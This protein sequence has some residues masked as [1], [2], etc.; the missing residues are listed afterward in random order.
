MRRARPARSSAKRSCTGS[1]RRR[2]KLIDLIGVGRHR[3]GADDQVELRLCHAA[4][5]ARAPA[6]CQRPRRR[7]HPRCRRLSGVDGAADRRRGG[8]QAVRR[9]GQGVRGRRISG[10][11]GVDEWAS[12][13]LQF[14]G[15][16]VAEVSCSVSVQQENVLRILGT[17]G[18]HRGA[19]LLV[20]RRQPRRRAGARSHVIRDDGTRETLTLGETAPPLFVRGGRR[21]P[22][23]SR[24]GRQEFAAPGMSWADSLGNLAGARQVAGR[25]R[26]RLRDREAGAA[27]ARR[28]RAGSS[29]GAATPIADDGRCRGCRQPTSLVALGFEFFPTFAQRVDHC[30]T[31]S[32]SAAATS[33]IPPGSTAAG[34]TES[35]VRRLAHEPRAQPRRAG[36]DRQGRALAAGLSRRHRQAADAVA[37]AAAR[38]TTSTSTSCTA[39]TRRCRSASSSMRWMPRSKPGASAAS[40]AARTGRASAWTR[41][42]PMPSAAASRRRARCPTTS[43]WPRCS[44]R[45]GPAASPCSDDEWKAWLK[46]RQIPN[47]AWSS[48]GRGFFTDRAG[49]D[50]HDDE[51]IVRVWYSEKNFGRR[52]R[53]IELAQ[54]AR[55]P[56]DPHRAG[57]CA[58]AAVP[59]GP[60]DRAAHASTSST[61]AS[62]RSTSRSRPSRC[63]GSN[64]GNES[65]LYRWRPRS[66]Q[67]SAERDNLNRRFLVVRSTP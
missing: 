27:D 30:S 14:P 45:S 51:E 39:T 3:R 21:W 32:T 34:K 23:R 43:R 28:W 59:G 22:M 64:P 40:S 17:T 47:F 5:H 4:V 15:G 13:V 29:S 12:A 54:A 44:T 55:P 35:A 10:S 52:D 7:R 20:R 8:G 33:S 67:P 46:A 18:R 42:S 38:P 60:A 6:L 48:Q 16:I 1:T 41:R 49:R 66:A 56:A 19:G 2:S 24:A 53:A 9:S 58:G 11:R 61:T 36:A 65:Q 57:L 37:R 26:A 63:A 31:A 62:R 25:R 50:K